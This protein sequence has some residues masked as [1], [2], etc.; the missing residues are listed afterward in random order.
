MLLWS[1]AS[2]LMSVPDEPSHAIRAVAVVHG[3]FTGH[4]DP[5]APWQIAVDVPRY[6]A[7]THEL[8]CFAFQADEPADCQLPVSGNG[9]EIVSVTTSAG[10]NS[11]VYYAIVG[12]PSLV[13]SGDAALYS[14]RFINA[15]VCA[16]LLAVMFMALRQLPHSRWAVLGAA[17]TVTPMVLFLGGAI[18]PNG[19][20]VA[21]TGSLLAVLLATFRT[22]SSN[23]LLWQRGALV[24]VSAVILT[25]TRSIALL[26]V[27]LAI[28][29]A[30]LL[31]RSDVI[32]PLFRRGAAWAVVACG[33]L[34][35]VLSLAWY[36]KPPTTTADGPGFEGVGTSFVTGFTRMIIETL[37]FAEE[38]IGLFGWVDRPAPTVTI[39]IWT[40]AIG[41][42]V[43]AALAITKGRARLAVILFVVAV[44]FVPAFS[45]AAIVTEMG[46][47]W[48]GRYTLA[49]L[50]CLLV[51]CGVAL[52]E[53]YPR[54]LAT[55]AGRRIATVSVT[56]L[57]VGQLAA[58]V[59]T[60]KRY[61]VG[62]RASFID[63][64]TS[65]DWQPPL[66]W[67]VLSVLM[68][69]SIVFG[70]WVCARAVGGNAV[71]RGDGADL[72]V[73]VAPVA[74]R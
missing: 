72:H 39:A 23:A 45:Q 26:W 25:S 31:A 36:L 15:I 69:V 11:P 65:P 20:E 62:E 67:I 9:D 50:L 64:L 61:V 32:K 48:Q 43:I 58:F 49:L 46:Y 66:G 41:A 40:V 68:L 28:A 8:P 59:W 12:L 19:M 73:P 33:A 5:A 17:V 42:F 35:S 38:W 52:D 70:V 3:D 27:L 55:T 7:H 47:I 6:I 4:P 51:V 10:A 53:T 21:A 54:A 56:L 63:M 16:A 2:P 71:G 34:A 24:V 18:N 29:G 22:P 30:L 44:V 60:L 14:M 37:D 57:G 74:L 13:L 1:L